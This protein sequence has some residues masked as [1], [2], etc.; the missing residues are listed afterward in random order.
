MRGLE[1]FHPPRWV[2]G[3][4]AGGGGGGED[5]QRDLE[6]VEFILQSL[7]CWFK[8]S[9]LYIFINCI[10]MYL[11]QSVPVPAPIPFTGPASLRPL[12]Q[13][14]FPNDSPCAAAAFSSSPKM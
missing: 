5:A 14:G 12:Y 7:F 1:L 8:N 10:N 3:R 4:D 9:F 2:R 6:F 13:S 11:Y